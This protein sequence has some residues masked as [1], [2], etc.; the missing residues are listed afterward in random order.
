MKILF[1]TTLPNLVYDEL[2]K[3][4]NI[5]VDLIDLG[6]SMGKEQFLSVMDFKVH[7]NTYYMLVTYR[8]PY[9]I[10]SIIRNRIGKCINIHPLSLPKYKGLNPWK[11]FFESGERQSEAVVHLMDDSFDN[12]EVLARWPYSFESQCEARSLSD[13]VISRKLPEF[14][15]TETLKQY[16]NIDK[17]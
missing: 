2:I 6:A 17:E 8:C 5:S 3:V 7:S 4:G 16:G 1:I 15:N 14:L 13:W 11:K 9:F 12:G 10:P